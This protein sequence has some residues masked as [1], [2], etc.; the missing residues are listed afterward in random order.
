MQSDISSSV[1]TATGSL[2]S[3]LAPDIAN[4][5]TAFGGIEL[6][7]QLH[8]SFD[9]PDFPMMNSKIASAT[10]S[11]VGTEWHTTDEGKGGGAIVSHDG[12]GLRLQG[13]E[14]DDRILSD[15]KQT[16]TFWVY[17]S[18][19]EIDTYSGGGWAISSY[20]S[21]GF[22]IPSNGD[23]VHFGIGRENSF[24]SEGKARIEWHRH[25]SNPYTTN[26]DMEIIS[27]SWNFV[28]MTMD[29]ENDESNVFYYSADSR[30]G[31][32]KEVVYHS[33]LGWGSSIEP[34]W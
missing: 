11:N 8:W 16:W 2:S 19:E 29:Y 25:D 3:S 22:G 30:A 20:L 14:G 34:D 31:K 5:L 33:G 4:S 26:T 6:N 12:G 13:G 9:N 17:D 7:C 10:A 27:G 1:D 32:P 28:A 18:G 23:K 15:T 21:R 24:D